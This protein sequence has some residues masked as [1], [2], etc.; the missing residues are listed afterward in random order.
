MVAGQVCK[1]NQNRKNRELMK[2]RS[3]A[4]KANNPEKYKS[5]KRGQ[6]D[7]KV[8]RGTTKNVCTILRNHSD[9]MRDD[10]EH[11]NPHHSKNA[12]PIVVS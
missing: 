2:L 12:H 8:K 9:N 5:S 11:L 3:R 6:N 4:W 10:P 1:L 7:K